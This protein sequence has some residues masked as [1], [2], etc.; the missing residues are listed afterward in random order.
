LSFEP[1]DLAIAPPDL[2]PGLLADLD[3]PIRDVSAPPS[4]ALADS[5]DRGL[6]SNDD[7]VGFHAAAAASISAPAVAIKSPK[8]PVR[9]SPSPPVTAELPLFVQGLTEPARRPD[10]EELL[11]KVP[12][13][14]RA[15]LAVRRP[16]PAPGRVREKYQREVAPARQ[17]GLLER[18]LL[19]MRPREETPPAP[20]LETPS[21]VA[22][23]GREA[24]DQPAGALRRIEAACVDLLFIGP[25]NVA[26]VWLTLQRCDLTFAEAWQLPM[27]PLLAYLFL[28]DSGYLLMFTLTNGQTVGKMAAGLRVIGASPDAVTNDHV[29]LRQAAVRAILTF[30]SVL[31]LGLGFAPA[32]LG[33]G[34]ALHDRFAH[35][36]VVRA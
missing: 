34:L 9:P 11:V 23:R 31:A 29:T 3:L 15:P 18:D 6:I 22:A 5:I 25:I 10:Q 33:R 36:R 14:P 17:A 13:A 21:P 24:Q 30:P 32:L 20:V 19:D 28:V 4:R 7:A 27:L 12:R 8:P 2:R 35:T 16:T 26:V 1:A